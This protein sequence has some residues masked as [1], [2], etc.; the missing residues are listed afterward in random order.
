MLDDSVNDG[1]CLTGSGS[2]VDYDMRVKIQGQSLSRVQSN[3]KDPS[4]LTS[5]ISLTGQYAQTFG[6]GVGCTLPNL[7]SLATLM[8]TESRWANQALK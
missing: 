7:A 6:E 4:I 5:Q 2:C 1:T 8:A 3:Q